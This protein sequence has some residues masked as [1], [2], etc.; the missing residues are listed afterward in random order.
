[1]LYEWQKPNSRNLNESYLTHLSHQYVSSSIEYKRVNHNRK[2]IIQLKYSRISSK[3][4]SRGVNILF[5]KNVSSNTLK[6]HK[7]NI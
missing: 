5:I 4:K 3:Y 7:I 2:A 1:M 6:I